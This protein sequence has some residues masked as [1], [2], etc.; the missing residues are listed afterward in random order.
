MSIPPKNGGVLIGFKQW[1]CVGWC[2]LQPK[3]GGTKRCLK[4]GEILRDMVEWEWSES[5]QSL[6][7]HKSQ[8]TTAHSQ[9]MSNTARSASVSLA[10]SLLCAVP[11]LF[12]GPSILLGNETQECLYS[13]FLANASFMI[14]H[15]NVHLRHIHPLTWTN[16]RLWAGCQICQMLLDLIITLVLLLQRNNIKT[17]PANLGHREILQLSCGHLV[18]AWHFFLKLSDVKLNFPSLIISKMICAQY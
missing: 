5:N 8:H 1:R 16:N 6:Q 18:H 13:S 12:C 17:I 3:A 11:L 7:W 10:S 15:P 2:H 9:K 4:K 14:A